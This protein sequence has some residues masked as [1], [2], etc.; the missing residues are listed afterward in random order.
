MHTQTPD[1]DSVPQSE[2]VIR[3]LLATL[4]ELLARVIGQA[5]ESQPDMELSG[6]AR[7][8]WELLQMA[9]H[10]V[11]VIVMGAPAISP[12]PGICSHLFAE[13]PDVKILVV[14]PTGT[15]AIRYWLAL[16][17]SKTTLTTSR[18]LL[19]NIRR[20]SKIGN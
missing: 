3:V 10:G 5:V 18:G 20:F 19:A 17:H 1:E 9:G 2:A 8:N 12:P 7:D 6:H 11:D 14:D 15:S 13:F 16:R 4:P